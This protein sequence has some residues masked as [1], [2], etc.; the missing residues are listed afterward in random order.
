[1]TAVTEGAPTYLGGGDPAGRFTDYYPAWV[2]NLADDATVEGSMLDGAVQGADAVRTIVTTIRLLYARQAFNYA[3]PWGDNRFI[4]HY[5]AR[6][7]GRPI[8][9][10][11]LVTLN[12]AGRTQHLAASYRPLSSVLFFSRLLREQLAGTPYAQY[13]LGSGSP[14]IATGDFKLEVV[15]LPVS[16]VDRAKAFYERLGW[17]LDADI[18]RGDAF[19]AVQF[20]PPHSDCSIAFGKGLTTG[21][22]GSVKRLLLVVDDVDAARAELSGR[23]IAVSEVFHL[24]GGRVPGRDPEGRSHQSYAA[25]SD[26]DGNEWLLQEIK[27]RLPGREW[28]D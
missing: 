6:V 20:T 24:A 3:G 10:V 19:R 1:M 7:R 17:R 23:G 22:P 16:D 15:T 11:A 21:G 8:A 2:D 26:P 18:A 28:Q 4:E 12:D 5:T 25:F 13:F 27:E 9:C 14:G